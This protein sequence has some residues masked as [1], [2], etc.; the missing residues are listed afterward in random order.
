MEFDFEKPFASVGGIALGKPPLHPQPKIYPDVASLSESKNYFDDEMLFQMST[1]R[2]FLALGFFLI[3][4]SFR[5]IYFAKEDNIKLERGI[6]LALKNLDEKINQSELK[7]NQKMK[8]TSLKLEEKTNFTKLKID[9]F[10]KESKIRQMRIDELS[11]EIKKLTT[12]ATEEKVKQEPVPLKVVNEEVREKEQVL[13]S[14]KTPEKVDSLPILQPSPIMKKSNR[15]K[16]ESQ[17]NK[18]NSSNK[19]K[20]RE[21]AL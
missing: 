4:L 9:E 20:S 10:S 6:A 2:A 17:T 1:L 3:A 19:S 12:T 16:K 7:V 21:I 15:K 14:I 5:E 18:S 8:E 13:P 11:E